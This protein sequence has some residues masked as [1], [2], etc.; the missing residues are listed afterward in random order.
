VVDTD[1]VVGLLQWILREMDSRYHKFSN[2]RVRNIQDFNEKKPEE[3]LPYMVVVIDELADLMMLAPDEVERSITRLAQLARATGIHLILAT[4]R[5]SVNVI[6]G[7]IKANFP[8][9]IA[10]AVAQGVDSRVILDQ[11]GAEKLLGRG[12]MLFLAPDASAPVRLQGAYVSDSEIELLVNYWKY[13][14]AVP[15]A[16]KSGTPEGKPID[17]VPAGI[18]LKQIPLW[19]EID[20]DQDPMLQDAISLVRQEKKASVTMLERRLRIGYTRAARI[21]EKLEEMGIVG[22]PLPGSQIREILEENP[23]PSSESEPQVN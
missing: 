18:P 3:H 8:A 22:P 15:D 10:F 21:V 16:E 14:A 19:D 5:P 7:Q 6:T 23:P 13:N 12:D 1:R 9:R 2:A 4:Q 17:T 20:S 11:S